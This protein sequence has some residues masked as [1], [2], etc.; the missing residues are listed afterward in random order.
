M[1]KYEEITNALRILGL[2]ESAIVKDIKDKY[3]ELIKEWHPDFCK[4]D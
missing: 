2:Y 1:G 3:R 4:G